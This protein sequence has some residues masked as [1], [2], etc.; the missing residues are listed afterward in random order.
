VRARLTDEDARVRLYA[1]SAYKLI[2]RDKF[3]LGEL[4]V[5][6]LADPDSSVREDARK[7]LLTGSR[8]V[9][10]AVIPLLSHDSPGDRLIAL[11]ILSFPRAIGLDLWN[12]DMIE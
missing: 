4:A 12:A 10:R 8:D 9:V 6:L 3:E 1:F 5:R 2:C 11:E 7:T